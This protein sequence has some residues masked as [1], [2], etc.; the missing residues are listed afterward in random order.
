MNKGFNDKLEKGKNLE[1]QARIKGIPVPDEAIFNEGV[2]YLTQAEK[3]SNLIKRVELIDKAID[4]LEKFGQ[5]D[6]QRVKI[7]IDTADSKL[8]EAKKTLFYENDVRKA[9]ELLTEAR[10]LYNREGIR[11]HFQK[12]KN[13]KNI[14]TGLSKNTIYLKS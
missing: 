7:E 13:L 4:I 1:D 11:M 10:K 8:K 2:Y 3:E 12:P 6:M 14:L 5:G 9:D